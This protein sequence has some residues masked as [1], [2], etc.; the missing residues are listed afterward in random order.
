MQARL[1]RAGSLLTTMPGCSGVL[2]DVTLRS[3]RAFARHQRPGSKSL[4]RSNGR[5]GRLGPQG[6][7][8]AA[9]TSGVA[10]P[11]LPGV[12]R[13]LCGQLARLHWGRTHTHSQAHGQRARVQRSSGC[14]AVL[15]CY[16]HLKEMEWGPSCTF[17]AAPTP[18]PVPC[19]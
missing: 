4:D 10:L 5:D 11:T 8:A 12:S 17:S 7:A 14:C 3:S 19:R 6:R 1:G 15:R 13:P 18:C 2:A 16:V 9:Q